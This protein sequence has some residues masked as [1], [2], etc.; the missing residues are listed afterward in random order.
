[1]CYLYLDTLENG[2]VEEVESS[3][4]LVGYE[5]SWF[6]DETF[7]PAVLF[8]NYNSIPRWLFYL[9]NLVCRG[10]YRNRLN[11]GYLGCRGCYMNTLYLGNLGCR[12]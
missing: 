9:C 3:V 8:V 10:C 4:D 7:Y 2:R 6:L 1:M 5:L 11:L 12:G